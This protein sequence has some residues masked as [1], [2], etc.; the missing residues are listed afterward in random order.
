VID[1]AHGTAPHH[2]VTA[3][4]VQTTHWVR[5]AFATPQEYGRQAERGGDDG[6]PSILLV[7]MEAELGAGDIG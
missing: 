3:F 5:A 1:E 6:S 7:L 4:K 2:D